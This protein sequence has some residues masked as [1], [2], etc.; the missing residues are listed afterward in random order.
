MEAKRNDYT[1]QFSL[2]TKPQAVLWLETVLKIYRGMLEQCCKILFFNS[3]FSLR[4]A[5]EKESSI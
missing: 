5:E 4:R 1:A 3:Y 2:P